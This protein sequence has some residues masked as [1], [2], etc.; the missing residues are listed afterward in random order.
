MAVPPGLQLPPLLPA[1]YLARD[2]VP[3]CAPPPSSTALARIAVLRPS[4]SAFSFP[5]RLRV[6]LLAD[7]LVCTAVRSPAPVR[8]VRFAPPY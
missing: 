7:P 6:A 1:S 8:S 2:Y 3:A 4:C 5:E